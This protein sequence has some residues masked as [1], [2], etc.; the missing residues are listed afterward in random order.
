MMQTSGF[1]L[2]ALLMLAVFV[3]TLSAGNSRPPVPLAVSSKADTLTLGTGA[4][5]A[6]NIPVENTVDNGSPPAA[7]TSSHNEDPRISIKDSGLESGP[8]SSA[9]PRAEVATAGRSDGTQV[10][11]YR[12][13]SPFHSEW[14]ARGFAQRLALATEVPVEV[15]N[16]EPGN[17]QVVF[18]YR[19]DAERQAM[20]KQIEA[21][22]G[23]VL[24]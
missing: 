18:R 16:E 19:D 10:S 24:E 22:T 15:V 7:D 4:I 17:Y 2:G 21:V 9:Q 1:L 12:V 23:L 14:A 11:R 20:V 8:Q 3:L 5:A 6:G 13:W